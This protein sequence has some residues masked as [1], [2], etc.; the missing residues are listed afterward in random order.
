[1]VAPWR[2]LPPPLEAGEAAR[3]GK[4]ATRP[5]EEEGEEEGTVLPVLPPLGSPLSS[6]SPAEVAVA[7]GGGGVVCFSCGVGR[8]LQRLYLAWPGYDPG[9]ASSGEHTPQRL[10]SQTRSYISDY[11]HIWTYVL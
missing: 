1:M 2:G 5:E 9:Q 4:A 6:W 3:Q 7:A 10:D 11:Y 8:R